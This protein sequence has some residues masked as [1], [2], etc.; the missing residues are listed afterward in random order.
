MTEML[1]GHSAT[2]LLHFCYSASLFFT[3]EPLWSGLALSICLST[4]KIVLKAFSFM[5]MLNIS[6]STERGFTIQK[7]QRDSEMD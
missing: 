3:K 6:P 4:K 1:L 7:H 2:T 5:A